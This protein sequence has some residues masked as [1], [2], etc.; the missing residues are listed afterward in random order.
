MSIARSTG[1]P[2]HPAVSSIR[3]D[4]SI[5]SALEDIMLMTRVRG[6][7]TIAKGLMDMGKGRWSPNNGF[8]SSDVR[9]KSVLLPPRRS[10]TYVTGG[11]DITACERCRLTKGLYERRSTR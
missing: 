11:F 4:R 10:L 9:S 6:A 3:T 8:R 5:G 1:L 7:G 2:L